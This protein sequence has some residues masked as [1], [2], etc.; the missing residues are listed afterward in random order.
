MEITM[1]TATEA[2]KENR[3][4]LKL[5]TGQGDLDSLIGGI[6]QGDFYLFYSSD[7]KILDHLLHRILVNCILPIE[8][9]G[10]DSKALYFNTCNY[11]QGKTLLNPSN[12]ATIAKSARIDPK[13]VFQNIYAISAFNERQ[14]I[15]TTK[16]AAE[17]V[18]K[19]EDVKLVAIHNL[20]RFIKTSRTP[21]K[22][23]QIVKQI[24]GIWKRVT[25][26]RG[27]A[28]V[29]TCSASRAGRGR[30]PKPVGGTYLR[31]EANV[32]VLLMG[33]TKGESSSVKATLVKHPY[34]KTPQSIVLYVPKESVTLTGHMTPSFRQQFQKLIEELKE[35]SAFQNTLISREHKKAFNLLLKDAWSAE[36]VAMANSGIPCVMDALNLMANVHNKKCV[37]EL[38]QK[39]QELE[40]V[41]KENL[42]K[43]EEESI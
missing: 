29:A 9:G 8:Q 36:D 42:E 32:V 4:K 33:A 30:M 31:H 15:T 43:K 13:I 12:L 18:K 19:D 41:L 20:T 27:A 1:Q 22:A 10:F 6:K 26:K 11:H 38:R 39:L 3:G 25:S 23:R 16:K 21:S 40:S 28:L 37:E 7:Q 17:L 35:S 14:Q 24:I 34:K 2:L 5:T